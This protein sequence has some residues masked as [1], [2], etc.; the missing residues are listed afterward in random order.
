MIREET[1]KRG[2]STTLGPPG[3]K[4]IDPSLWCFY[5]EVGLFILNITRLATVKS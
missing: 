5:M 3:L 1:K 2:H 4:L